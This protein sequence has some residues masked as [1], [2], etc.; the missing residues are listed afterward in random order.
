M[1]KH[2]LWFL[3]HRGRC[4]V[5]YIPSLL[6][7][8]PVF[9]CVARAGLGLWMINQWLL[10]SNRHCW[11]INVVY[12]LP[13][14]ST[15]QSSQHCWNFLLGHH[16]PLLWR[17]CFSVPVPLMVPSRKG[18]R[19]LWSETR[20]GSVS[21]VWGCWRSWFQGCSHQCSYGIALRGFSWSLGLILGFLCQALSWALGVQ[22]RIKSDTVS[23]RI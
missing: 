1:R 9:N 19:A 14:K 8:F 4:S 23:E 2:L 7:S 10:E 3:A 17:K 18:V 5:Y 12:L 13:V 6:S 15:L 21:H 16:S 20:S 22:N 11:L